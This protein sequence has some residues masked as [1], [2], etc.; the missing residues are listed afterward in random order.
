[1][2]IGDFDT[3][4]GRQHDV[5][6]LGR[7]QPGV[8]DIGGDQD[9]RAAGRFERAVVAQLAGVALGIELHPAGQE[10][11]VPDVERRRDQPRGVHLRAGTEQHAIRIDQ[12]NAAIGDQVAEDSRRILTDHA[13]EHAGGRARLDEAGG[14][15]RLD[16]KLLPV[17]DG[18]VAGRDVQRTALDLDADV[19]VDHLMTGRVGNRKAGQRSRHRSHDAPQRTCAAALAACLRFFRHR[20]VA[21][22]LFGKNQS[23]A[24]LVHFG[25]KFFSARP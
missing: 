7:D 14:F 17:D 23:V 25:L 10:V 22:L 12:E 20:D 21:A 9:Q 13:V 5:A 19:A 1:M 4:A 11:F 3:L 18:L 6:V 2:R 16:G 15:T 8:F 24:T